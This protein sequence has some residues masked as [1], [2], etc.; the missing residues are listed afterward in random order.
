MSVIS[1]KGISYEEWI[2]ER[3]LSSHRT[4]TFTSSSQSLRLTEDFQ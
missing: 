3:K 2:E 4:P 1:K